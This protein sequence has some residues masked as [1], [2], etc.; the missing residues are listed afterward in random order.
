MGMTGR[1]YDL[2]LCLTGHE[3][4]VVDGHD[5][6]VVDPHRSR[7]SAYVSCRHFRNFL[8]DNPGDLWGGGEREWGTGVSG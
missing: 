6:T 4:P 2:L 7:E 3:Y 5:R 1:L 8:V